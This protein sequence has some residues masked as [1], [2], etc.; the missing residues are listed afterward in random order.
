[1]FFFVAIQSVFGFSIFSF[2]SNSLFKEPFFLLENYKIIL[3]MKDVYLALPAIFFSNLGKFLFD[4]LKNQKYTDFTIDEMMFKP[5][6]R[7]FIQQFV[8]IISMFFVVLSQNGIIAAIILIIIRWFIDLVLDAIKRNSKIFEYLSE[9]LANDKVDK[10][11]VEKQ[12]LL[13]S[14]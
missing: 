7:I 13:F 9:K 11:E 8:V 12:L 6:V 5:Y 4:F 2:G 14:E 10:K 3:S 1:Y